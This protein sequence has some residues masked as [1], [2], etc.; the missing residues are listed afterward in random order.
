M[1]GLLGKEKV[2]SIRFILVSGA[3]YWIIIS[4]DTQIFRK[5]MTNIVSRITQEGDFHTDH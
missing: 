4:K 1:N 5:S 2:N 3:R